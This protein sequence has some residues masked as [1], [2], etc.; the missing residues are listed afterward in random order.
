MTNYNKTLSTLPADVKVRVAFANGKTAAL[1]AQA[2]RATLESAIKKHGAIVDVT[3]VEPD[4]LFEFDL[5]RMHAHLVP[6]VVMLDGTLR[7]A[8][9][10]QPSDGCAL[11]TLSIEANELMGADL[12]SYVTTSKAVTRVTTD[13]VSTLFGGL[14]SVGI[15]Y[16]LALHPQPH[17]LRFG[18]GNETMRDELERAVRELAGHIDTAQEQ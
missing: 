8:V 13:C 11:S 10:K 15:A 7:L 12:N 9:W 14:I 3:G 18:G 6:E 5:K 17:P 1:A 16:H 2:D 4:A